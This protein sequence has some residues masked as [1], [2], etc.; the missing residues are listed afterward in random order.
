MFCPSL[1]KGHRCIVTVWPML[2]YMVQ[3]ASHNQWPL[4]I[5]TPPCLWPLPHILAFLLSTLLSKPRYQD[6]HRW[7]HIQTPAGPG[8]AKWGVPNGLTKGCQISCTGSLRATSSLSR[9][10]D[11]STIKIDKTHDAKIT[12][13]VNITPWRPSWK[14]TLAF[15]SFF[16]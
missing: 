10:P 11:L 2:N 15:K 16:D 7:W 6:G 12:L 4:F 14:S 8:L 1:I 13:Y 5:A 3:R 9:S